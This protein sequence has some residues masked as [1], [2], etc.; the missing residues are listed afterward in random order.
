MEEELNGEGDLGRRPAVDPAVGG[1]AVPAPFLAALVALPAPPAVASRDLGVLVE[2][3][4]DVVAGVGL[5]QEDGKV[6]VRTL[7]KKNYL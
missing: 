3:A 2:R 4:K 1:Q 6:Q 5:G 7:P